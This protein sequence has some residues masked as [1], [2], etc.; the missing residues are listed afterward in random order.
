[1]P[2]EGANQGPRVQTESQEQPELQMYGGIWGGL[3][4]ILILVGL[5][6]WLSAEG[7]GGTKAFWAAGWLAIVA[8]LLLAKNKTRYCGSVM[9]DLGDKNGIVIVTAWLFAGVFGKLMVAGGLVDGLL[10]FG[11]TSGAQGAA[12]TLVAFVAAMLFALGTGTS[13]GTVLSLVPRAV[14]GGCIPGSQSGRAGHHFHHNPGFNSDF[15]QRPRRAAGRS[16][17]GQT[18]WQEIQAGPGA[19]AQS[20]GLCGVYGLLHAPLAYCCRGLEKLVEL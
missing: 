3:V 8:G 11:L 9:R 16:Q 4:P 6:V 17:P 1:M 2:P 12:F 19:A 5:L 20:H 18:H 7:V 14:P 15:S 13:T 10:W